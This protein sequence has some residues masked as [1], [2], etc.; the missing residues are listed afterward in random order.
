MEREQEMI[1]DL[2]NKLNILSSADPNE[3]KE[4]MTEEI[5]ANHFF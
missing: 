5:Q 3:L 1:K 4:K 2:E